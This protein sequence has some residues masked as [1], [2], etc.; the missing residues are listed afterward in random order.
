MKIFPL[1][2]LGDTGVVNDVIET[3]VQLLESAKLFF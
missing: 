1:F 2:S 3:A